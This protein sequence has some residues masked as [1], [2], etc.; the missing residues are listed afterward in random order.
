MM[1]L[2]LLKKTRTKMSGQGGRIK[3][4]DTH[5]IFARIREASKGKT[6]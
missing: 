3:K 1:L 5:T 2:V 6:R 4:Q